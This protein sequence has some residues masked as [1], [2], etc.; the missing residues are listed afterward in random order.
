MI[1]EE[2]KPQEAQLAM[3]PEE[4]KP[5]EE[6][7]LQEAIVA[8]EPEKEKKKRRIEQIR[9]WPQMEEEEEE[10]EEETL[11]AE[12]PCWRSSLNLAPSTFGIV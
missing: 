1:P 5:P 2:K 9:E 4:K 12:G 7:K 8:P 3:I 11:E 6:K 10:E